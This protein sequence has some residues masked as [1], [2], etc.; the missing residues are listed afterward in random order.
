[1]AATSETKKMPSGFFR[2]VIHHSTEVVSPASKVYVYEAPVRFW[3][4]MNALCIVALV[5]TGYLIGK[6]PP[7]IGGE[8][9]D[10]FLFGDIRMIHFIS[11]QLLIVLLVYRII[12]SFFGNEHSHQLFLPPLWSGKWWREVLH[13]VRWYCF[14]EKTPKKY[15]GHNPL[16]Q[17]AM[18][19]V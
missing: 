11:G 17:L 6:P 1:M 12:W 9:S 4:W 16:A 3:H 18:F 13:E 5:I 10:H 19:T 8:A 7:S 14:L 2:K 15:I